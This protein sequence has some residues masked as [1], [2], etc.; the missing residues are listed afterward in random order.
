MMND[1]VSA[2]QVQV[3]SLTQEQAQAAVSATLGLLG[4]LEPAGDKVITN[5][6]GCWV[7]DAA[8]GEIIGKI[9]NGVGVFAG[10]DENGWTPILL[11]GWVGN[12]MLG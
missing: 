2:L 10:K 5:A 8:S 1:L 4:G 6:A 7:R 9:N 12:G 3:P 11:L